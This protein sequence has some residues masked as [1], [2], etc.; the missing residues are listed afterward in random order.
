MKLINYT[1]EKMRLIQSFMRQVTGKAIVCDAYMDDEGNAA[2]HA[3]VF[4]EGGGQSQYDCAA[5]ALNGVSGLEVSD[6]LAAGRSSDEGAIKAKSPNGWGLAHA[7][8]EDG[9][10]QII[11]R[12]QYLWRE[13]TLFEWRDEIC[14]ALMGA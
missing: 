5:L 9:G 2:L 13:E 3:L 10:V 11:I 1:G 6:R 4:G 7:T 14:A 8:S 12:F